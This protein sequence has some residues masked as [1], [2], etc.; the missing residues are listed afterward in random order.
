MTVLPSTGLQL[1]RKDLEVTS[2]DADQKAAASAG[3]SSGSEQVGITSWGA[4]WPPPRPAPTAPSAHVPLG[5]DCTEPGAGGQRP[6]PAR[7]RNTKKDRVSS[8]DGQ[9]RG[10]ACK[11]CR[12]S[13][14]LPQRLPL[15]TLTLNQGFSGCSYRIEN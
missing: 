3:L 12:Q 9:I 7:T 2:R 14:A 1:E 11:P 4:P 10:L 5:V 13:C 15:H 6:R 8:C